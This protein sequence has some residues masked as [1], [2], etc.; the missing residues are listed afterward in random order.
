MI[1]KKKDQLG[2]LSILHMTIP[3]IS[4]IFSFSCNVTLA[5]VEAIIGAVKLNMIA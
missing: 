4:A 1:K 5:T 2:L 3:P